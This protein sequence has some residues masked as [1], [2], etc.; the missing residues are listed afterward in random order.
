V[1]ARRR[2]ETGGSRRR[3]EPAETPSLATPAHVSAAAA[4][5]AV[6]ILP[7]LAVDGLVGPYVDGKVWLLVLLAAV[8]GVAWL[9]G[10]RTARPVPPGGPLA[11]AFQVAVLAYLGWGLVAT[12]ASMAPGL[13]LLGEFGRGQGLLTIAAAVVLGALVWTR[14]WRAARWLGDLALLGSVPV[15]VLALGQALGWDPLP[16]TQ[17]DPA[18]ARLRVRSTL[19]THIFLGGYLVLVAPITMVRLGAAWDAACRPAPVGAGGPASRRLDPGTWWGALWT[20]GAVGAV[21]LA[22]AWP[23][24]AWAVVPLG[25]IVAVGWLRSVSEDAPEAGGHATIWSLAGLLVLQVAVVVLTRARGPFL[26]FLVGLSLTGLG[27][28]IVRRA[29]VAMS[30]ALGGLAVIV[31]LIVLLNLPGSPLEP[32][33]NVPVLSRFARLAETRPGSPGWVR[34]QAWMG[35]LEGWRRQLGGAPVL[36]G[37]SPGLRSLLGYGPDTQGVTL[38]PLVRPRL[39]PAR[40]PAGRHWIQYFIDRAHN[41]PLDHVLTGGLIGLATWL[42]TTATLL[43]LGVARVA[44]APRNGQEVALRLGALGAVVGHLVETQVG[45][46]TPVSRAFFALAAGLLTMPPWIT[47]PGAPSS[48]SRTPWIGR[49]L[50]IAAAIGAGMAVLASTGW[51]FASGRFASGSRAWAARDAPAAYRAFRGS[52]DAAPWLA[53]PAEAAAEVALTLAAQEPDPRR[54]RVLLTE[55]AHALDRSRRA[56][57]PTA[58]HWTLRAQIAQGQAMAGGPGSLAE[59]VEAYTEAVRLRPGDGHLHAL[60]AL[61]LLELGD[62]AQA[63]AAAERA[64]AREPST[65][66]AWAVLARSARSLGD[67]RR[68]EEAAARARDLAPASAKALMERLAP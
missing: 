2:G 27:L 34:L 7:S 54:R 26:G 18:M 22:A 6:L 10:P 35:I 44:A 66:L 45:V 51:L 60:R 55:A 29:W 19:G 28:L 47:T 38:E 33:R 24:A 5:A 9:A 68:A 37:A 52:S 63:R 14:S 39:G 48:S 21:A 56:A 57:W 16:V 1:T 23:P 40:G 61:A 62:P 11:R 13:S 8:A 50:W 41:D 42:A 3:D 59:A 67:G 30:W 49:P 58:E 15:C 31:T 65:W 12:S 46:E 25:V 53:R 36:P 17:Y 32:L 4:G 43:V 20:V 64:I